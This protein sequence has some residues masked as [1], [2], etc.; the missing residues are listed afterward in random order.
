MP[1]STSGDASFWLTYRFTRTCRPHQST[2]TAVGE[3]VALR[4]HFRS[5]S[6]TRL[7]G[8]FADA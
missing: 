2:E 8:D 4:A 7:W 6:N 5:A 1:L 3:R